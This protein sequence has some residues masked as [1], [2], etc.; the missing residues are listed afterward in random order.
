MKK[1]IVALIFLA[2]TT[3]SQQFPV[4]AFEMYSDEAGVPSHTTQ[5]QKTLPLM[6]SASFNY[7]L[8]FT[9]TLSDAQIL[10]LLDSATVHNM[11]IIL[12]AVTDKYSAVQRFYL[13]ANDD[14]FS[15][16]QGI[17][18]ADNDAEAP[19]SMYQKSSLKA[20]VANDYMVKDVRYQ[21]IHWGWPG[22]FN[23][24]AVFRLKVARGPDSTQ[25]LT[26]ARRGWHTSPAG[27]HP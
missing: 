27:V 13:D 17:A 23:Y 4:S 8:P 3:H 25:C 5:L 12:P 14:Y 2:A 21:P 20:T 10:E 18:V 16:H 1:I 15:Y 11:K 26:L 9:G 6:Q 22:D 7:G 24:K 19:S